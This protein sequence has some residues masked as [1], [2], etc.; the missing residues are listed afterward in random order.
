[1][2]VISAAMFRVGYGMTQ[3][4]GHIGK[5]SMQLG[6]GVALD[7]DRW[8]GTAIQPRHRDV[9]AARQYT[10]LLIRHPTMLASPALERSVGIRFCLI[11][12]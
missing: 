3:S 5:Q 4:A 12:R 9:S 8:R 1:M 10:G 2:L 6:E 7:M 11:C